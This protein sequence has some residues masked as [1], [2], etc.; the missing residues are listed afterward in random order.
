MPYEV[1]SY[2]LAQ[3][4]F[5]CIRESSVGCQQDLFKTLNAYK[6][7]FSGSYARLMQQPFSRKLLTAIEEAEA[8]VADM[9]RM[10]AED[11][12]R[13]E[14]RKLAQILSQLG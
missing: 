6:E 4:L 9:Q 8:F 10:E 3:A 11:K 5:D 13:A 2:D 7:R 12:A 1:D 14:M